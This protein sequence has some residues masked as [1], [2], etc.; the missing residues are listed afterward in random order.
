MLRGNEHRA[1]TVE[2]KIQV[3]MDLADLTWSIQSG[4]IH[5]CVLQMQLLKMSTIK[6]QKKKSVKSVPHAELSFQQV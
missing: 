2:N 6:K 5:K 4:T 3:K 1:L